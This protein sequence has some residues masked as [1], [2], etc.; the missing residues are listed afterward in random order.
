MMRYVIDVSAIVTLVVPEDDSEKMQALV[1]W[2]RTGTIRLLTP[3]F[4]LTECANV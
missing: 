1:A 2:H 4:A 3:D